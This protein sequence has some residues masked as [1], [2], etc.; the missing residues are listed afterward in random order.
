MIKPAAKLNATAVAVLLATYGGASTLR[1]RWH[2]L[3]LLRQG[4]TR[5]T[6]ADLLGINPRTLRDWIAWYQMGGCAEVTRHQLGAGNGQSCRLTDERLAELAAWAAEGT[7]YTYEEAR[8]WVA[9]T[10]QVTYTYDGLRGVRRT[11]RAPRRLAGA[12]NSGSD[13]QAARGASSP[14]GE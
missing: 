13:L 12:T 9:S 6:V 8:Q 3:W 7:F 4:Y 5:K 14:R 1:P 10:W 2:A 11:R